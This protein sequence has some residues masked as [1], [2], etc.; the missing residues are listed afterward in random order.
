MISKFN[1]FLDQL[2]FDKHRGLRFKIISILK[3]E[4]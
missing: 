4:V 2:V 3:K 1:K